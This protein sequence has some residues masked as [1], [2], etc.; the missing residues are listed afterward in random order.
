[1]PL[2]VSVPVLSAQTTSTRAN[3]SMAGN[4]CTRH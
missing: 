1:M 2:S 3:P 4:S